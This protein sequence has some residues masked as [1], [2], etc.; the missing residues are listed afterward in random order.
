AKPVFACGWPAQPHGIAI[1]DSKAREECGAGVRNQRSIKMPETAAAKVNCQQE[2]GRGDQS[3]ERG[4][5]NVFVGTWPA[6]ERL[7]EDTVH[8]SN[9][10]ICGIALSCY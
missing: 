3:P 9:S 5:D 7:F 8:S 10:P 1:C 4:S 2:H 6:R